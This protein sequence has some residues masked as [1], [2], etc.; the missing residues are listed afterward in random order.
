MP[1]R[2]R[3]A[4]GRPRAPA[5][6]LGQVQ[7]P[8]LRPRQ[9]SGARRRRVPEPVRARDRRSCAQ[10]IDMGVDYTASGPIDALGD[11]IVTY[12]QAEGAGWGPYSCSGGHGGAVVYTA[13]RRRRPGPLRVRDRGDH[14]GGRRR[15]ADLGRAAG[16]RR[17]PAASRPAG[18]GHRRSAHGRR[19]RAG[20]QRT[21]T[22]AATRTWCGHN[23]SQLIAATGGPGRGAAARRDGGERMLSRGAASRRRWR[24][25][26]RWSLA[27]CGISDPYSTGRHHRPRAPASAAEPAAPDDDGPSPPERGRNAARRARARAP[28]AA[29]ARYAALYVNWTAGD[30]RGGRAAAR[31]A[32][33]RPGARPG[34]GAR[35]APRAARDARDTPCPNSGQRGGDR[36]GA[37]S[38][39][40]PLGGRHRRADERIRALPGPAGHE[41]RHLGD[42]RA[43]RAGAGWCPAGTRGA[44]RVS[45][46]AYGSRSG[47]GRS[48]DLGRAARRRPARG[49]RSTRRAARWS[50]SA[51]CAAA[52]APARSPTRSRRPRPSGRTQPVFACET[53]RDHRRP[54]AVCA[55]AQ[56]AS[57][58]GSGAANQVAAGTRRPGWS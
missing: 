7:A 39:A 22:P 31:I 50:R 55:R 37:G 14:P 49:S 41:P 42:G 20:V 12:S 23:M 8:A 16:R 15:P 34:A 46:L 30:A 11:G 56:P 4:G 17:S 5:N 45:A 40:R 52:R 13:R 1:A 54:G 24:P 10:R 33:D 47:C 58:A 44:E 6:A 43:R 21:A 26:S 2:H 57:V 29:L 32:V 51:G 9:A 3:H 28:Q 18:D 53:Q 35:A 19:A 25:C 36:R 27:G 38:R 48:R